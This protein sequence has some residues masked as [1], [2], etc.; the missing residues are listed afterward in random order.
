MER[1]K[2][3]YVKKN[4]KEIKCKNIIKNTKII[5]FGDITREKKRT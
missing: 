4:K 5:Y 3:Y 2:T 1:A